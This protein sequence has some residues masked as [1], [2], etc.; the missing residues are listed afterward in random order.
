[1]EIN[2]KE[3]FERADIKHFREFVLKENIISNNSYG[4]YQERLGRDSEDIIN[5]L[6]RNLKDD[7]NNSP[8]SEAMEELTIAFFTY[9]D[10]Y[11]EI[12]IKIGARLLLQLLYEDC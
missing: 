10:V 4:T 11:L 3:I 6:K 8:F 9:R 7:E 12:G 1:M 5:S 2:T